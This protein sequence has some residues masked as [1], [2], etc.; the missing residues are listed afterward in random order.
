MCTAM[1]LPIELNLAH[2]RRS[3]ESLVALG[4]ELQ[5][6]DLDAVIVG[7]YFPS[8]KRG[9]QCA[10]CLSLHCVLACISMRQLQPAVRE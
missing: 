5:S 8:C 2:D 3:D 6:Q 9:A 10:S 1:D 4:P 7:F